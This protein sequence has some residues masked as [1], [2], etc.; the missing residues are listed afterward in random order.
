MAAGGPEM[1]AA[2][3]EASMGGSGIPPTGPQGRSGSAIPGAESGAAGVIETR[4]DTGLE[5][6]ALGKV[7]QVEALAGAFQAAGWTH[8]VQPGATL[9]LRQ[10]A[11]SDPGPVN[12]GHRR[13]KRRRRGA[14]RARRGAEP[15]RLRGALRL[16]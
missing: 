2:G 15:A 3:R 14:E 13:A 4:A 9:Q 7:A 8:P 6:E 12:R 1:A 10:G 16:A 11:N 5:A